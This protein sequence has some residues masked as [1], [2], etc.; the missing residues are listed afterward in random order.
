V[1]QTLTLLALGLAAR[2]PAAE[3][4]V[5]TIGRELDSL[6]STDQVRYFSFDTGE[7]TELLEVGQELVVGDE[8]VALTDDLFVELTCPEGSQIHVTGKFRLQVNLAASG[9]DCAIDSRGGGLDVLTDAKVETCSAGVCAATGGTRYAVT[10]DRS[11]GQ[12]EQEIMVFDGNVAVTTKDQ[13]TEVTSKRSLRVRSRADSASEVTFESGDVT[14]SKLDWWAAVYARYDIVNARAAGVELSGAALEEAK[15]DFT[16]L[17]TLVL[18]DPDASAARAELATKQVD[19]KVSR[20]ALYNAR[21]AGL[22]TK[23]QVDEQEIDPGRLRPS[24]EVDRRKLEVLIKT[25]SGDGGVH[26]FTATPQPEAAN[27]LATNP[28]VTGPLAAAPPASGPALIGPSARSNLTTASGVLDLG[29]PADANAEQRTA[30][31]Q[32]QVALYESC[33]ERGELD[34]RNTLAG[35]RANFELGDKRTASGLAR[36]A[37]ALNRSESLLS[38]RELAYAAELADGY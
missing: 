10:L 7:E 16:R 13:R 3:V 23:E 24:N 26:G 28:L 36:R 27:L 33:A 1:V 30:Y 38:A 31:W 21:R 6:E 35:A 4:T 34:A 15:A 8:V 14:A 19:Y 22:V 32:R 18:E 20:A 9:Q 5:T 12:A 2:V 25:Q 17:Y 29:P 37:L 11:G